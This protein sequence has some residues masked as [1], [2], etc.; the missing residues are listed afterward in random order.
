M[1]FELVTIVSGGES[2]ISATQAILG[3]LSTCKVVDPN[4]VAS[5]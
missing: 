4:E 1:P 2:L 5:Q 3:W